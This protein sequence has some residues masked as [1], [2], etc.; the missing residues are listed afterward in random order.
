[1]TH[2]RSRS[3]Y[4]SRDCLAVGTFQLF[5]VLLAPVEKLQL[6]HACQGERGLECYEG[7]PANLNN[8]VMLKMLP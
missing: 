2:L 5:G 3:R 4:L 7:A 1:M 6:L 8:A